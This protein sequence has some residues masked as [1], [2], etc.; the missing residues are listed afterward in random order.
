MRVNIP[1]V[2]AIWSKAM[3]DP[4]EVLSKIPNS[5][6]WSKF[7]Q[8]L[9]TNL[10]RLNNLRHDLTNPPVQPDEDGSQQYTLYQQVHADYNFVSDKDAIAQAAFDK[11]VE[12]N[13]L[14][15]RLEGNDVDFA[16]WYYDATR[17]RVDN[18]MLELLI[19]IISLMLV[20]EHD[21]ATKTQVVEYQKWV[22]SVHGY[23]SRYL[24]GQIDEQT[25]LL[26]N[27]DS[28]LST[29]R[30]LGI[31]THSDMNALN[32]WQFWTTR[33]LLGLVVALVAVLL[34]RY[35][36]RL[37]PMLQK[38]QATVGREGTEK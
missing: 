36:A 12:L 17:K 2:T 9:Q 24:D 38:L 34:V 3:K 8:S 13:Y 29:Q 5:E 30:R 26:E 20:L 35:A 31:F 10:E 7:K 1:P 16:K 37:T 25:T 4:G 21:Y 32:Q 22:L 33:V 14:K 18:R 23:W 15:Y 27:M 28:L 19:A 6:R 11:E